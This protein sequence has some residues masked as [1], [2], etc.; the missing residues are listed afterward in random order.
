MFGFWNHYLTGT[1]ESTAAMAPTMNISTVLPLATPRNFQDPFIVAPATKFHPVGFVH[2]QPF[3][4]MHFS[5]KQRRGQEN[6][7]KKKE[8]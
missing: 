2:F 6:T 5:G 3:P 8:C 7:F 4:T 1:T